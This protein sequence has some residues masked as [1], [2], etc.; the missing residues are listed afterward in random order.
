MDSE[1][2]KEER[3]QKEREEKVHPTIR[4]SSVSL[5]SICT[6]ST[7]LKILIFTQERAAR[8]QNLAASSVRWV[9]GPTGTII[10]FPEAVGL[11]SIFNSKPHRYSNRLQLSQKK[12]AK[13]VT[14]PLFIYLGHAAT[15][16]RGR[17]VQGRHARMRIGIETPS[18]TFLSAA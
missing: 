3:K 10:S 14:S 13:N 9:M 1:K 7:L 4:L 6:G 11:P 17:N 15:L 8:E 5:A 16:P 2:K 12:I 18:L